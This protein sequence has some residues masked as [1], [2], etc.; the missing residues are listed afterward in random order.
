MTL[1]QCTCGKVVTTK[2]A[3][4]VSRV[5]FSVSKRIDTLW[6]SCDECKS[7]HTLSITMS[8]KKVMYYLFKAA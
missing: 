1:K 6:F 4:K 8:P 7:T 5:P 2:N 3:K